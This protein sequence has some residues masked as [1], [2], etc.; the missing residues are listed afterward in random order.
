MEKPKFE[1]LKYKNYLRMLENSCGSK[2]FR[3]VFVL[4]G[5]KERDILKNGELSCAYF[6]SCLLKIFDLIST[7]HA[8][9]NGMVKDMEKNGWKETEK[10]KPGDVL[11]WEK[12]KFEDGESHSHI[13]FYLGDNKAIS[14]SA[15]KGV[16]VIHHYTFGEAKDGS[17]KRK[18]IKIITYEIIK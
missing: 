9:V 12:K 6:V 3:S 18:I 8:T 5:G 15:K 17:P 13:G 14:N 11:V 10:M 2:M 1:V 4:D 16:P 7:S